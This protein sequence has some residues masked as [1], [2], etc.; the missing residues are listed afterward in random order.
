VKS[1]K[2]VQLELNEA[3]IKLPS[4]SKEL[5]VDVAKVGGKKISISYVQNNRNKVDVYID[6]NLFSGDSPYKDLKAA[7]KEM[8]D[9][10]KVMLNM[11]EEGINIE[12]IINEI[13]I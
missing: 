10:K 11:S 6:G 4:G 9:I 13:N 1:F 8:K 12:E 7:E 5:K 3:K 2:A